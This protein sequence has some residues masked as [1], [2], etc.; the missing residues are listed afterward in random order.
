MLFVVYLQYI[1]CRYGIEFGSSGST[2]IF[3]SIYIYPPLITGCT[4]YKIYMIN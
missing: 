1:G 3:L 2:L 4:V